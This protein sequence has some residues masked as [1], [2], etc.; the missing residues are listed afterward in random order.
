[1]TVGRPDAALADIE[2]VHLYDPAD[3]ELLPYRAAINEALK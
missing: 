2:A 3:T 1:M